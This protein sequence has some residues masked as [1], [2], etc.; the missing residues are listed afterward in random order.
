MLAFASLPVLGGRKENHM[1]TDPAQQFD[2]V[3]YKET[4]REQW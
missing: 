3:K 4:S 1:S 2:P